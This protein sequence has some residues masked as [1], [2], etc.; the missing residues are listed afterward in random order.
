LEHDLTGD[1]VAPP[2]P[3]ASSRRRAAKCR[4]R[5]RRPQQ[6]AVA[7]RPFPA[8]TP[9]RRRDPT[10][11]TERPRGASSNS[12]AASSSIFPDAA[13]IGEL[14]RSVHGKSQENL[15][16][17]DQNNLPRGRS[18]LCMRTNDRF[19]PPVEVLCEFSVRFRL[20]TPWSPCGVQALTDRSML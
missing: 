13:R 16:Q 9:R 19:A 14:S 4:R 2:P 18:Y 8:P 3:A 5:R 15:I 12:P 20:G 17:N 10:T 11:W 6:V 7:V 1:E